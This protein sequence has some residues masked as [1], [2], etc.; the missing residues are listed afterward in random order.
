MAVGEPWPPPAPGPA[1]AGRWS[2]DTYWAL[3]LLLLLLSLEE[4]IPAPSDS[5]GVAA[6]SIAI[7]KK[8]VER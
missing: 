6:G 4:F 3:P 8:I 2:E 7:V 1:G 5:W